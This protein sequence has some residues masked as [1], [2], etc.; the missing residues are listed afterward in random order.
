MSA[1]DQK[2]TFAGTFIWVLSDALAR[3]LQRPFEYCDPL[4]QLGG[5]EFRVHGGGEA[6]K[7]GKHRTFI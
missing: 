3:R 4:A 1:N 2:Q 5:F 6:G 7:A